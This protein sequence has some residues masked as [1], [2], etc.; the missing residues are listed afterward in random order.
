L[1]TAAPE[2]ATTKR[3]RTLFWLSN[4]AGVSGHPT[5]L[6]YRRQDII[7]YLKYRVEVLSNIVFSSVSYSH[8]SH[9][10]TNFVKKD[11]FGTWASILFGNYKEPMQQ[12]L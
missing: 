7:D 12:G 8:V 1:R 9:L 10:I 5:I 2:G 11:T 4:S 6:R 3:G